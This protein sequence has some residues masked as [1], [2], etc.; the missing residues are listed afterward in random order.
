MA[1]RLHA[2]VVKCKMMLNV[3]FV[4]SDD[5]LRIVSLYLFAKHLAG[6]L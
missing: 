3:V 1:I 4:T 2:L 5:Q 6:G